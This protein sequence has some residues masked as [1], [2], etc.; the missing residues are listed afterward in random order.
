MY[1]RTKFQLHISKFAWVRQLSENSQNI[2]NSKKFECLSRFL[3]KSILKFFDRYNIFVCIFRSKA[4]I[5]QKL[6]I[7]RLFFKQC[8]TS[9][10]NKSGIKCHEDSHDWKV[11]TALLVC[12]ISYQYL[13]PFMRYRALKRWKS[14]TRTHTNTSGSQLKIIFLA[15]FNYSEYSDANISNFFLLRKQS[16]FSEEAESTHFFFS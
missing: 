15:V 16:F 7:L 3:P 2:Q 11:V 8:Q 1:L 14:S 9:W 6:D 13:K 10:N 4:R 5:F 12:Q